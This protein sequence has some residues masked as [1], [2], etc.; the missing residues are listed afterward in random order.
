ML[1]KSYT[2]RDYLYR[3]YESL[4]SLIQKFCM[5]NGITEATFHKD[6]CKKISKSNDV[7]QDFN[8]YHIYRG[9]TS[10]ANDINRA[11]NITEKNYSILNCFTVNRM[12]TYMKEDLYYCP[13]CMKYGYHSIFHQLNFMNKCFIH[14][15]Q[16][17]IAANGQKYSLLFS[18]RE[19]YEGLEGFPNTKD[20]T[21]YKDSLLSEINEMK[22]ELP[23]SIKIID[24]NYEKYN[25][26]VLSKL[27]S[28]TKKLMCSLMFGNN[29]IKPIH[30]VSIKENDKQFENL[31]EYYNRTYRYVFDGY[32][33]RHPK[34][35]Y[36]SVY[37][38]IYDHVKKLMNNISEY[39]IHELSA[40]L[41]YNKNI[42]YN[43]EDKYISFLTSSAFLCS[44]EDEHFYKLKSV[45]EYD[46]NYKNMSF[47][48]NLS[49]L[50]TEIISHD[51]LKYHYIY[52]LVFRRIA[53]IVYNQ[54]QEQ[55]YLAYGYNPLWYEYDLKIPQYVITLAD[56]IFKIYEC[57]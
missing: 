44:L 43:E 35:Y 28:S 25:Y 8:L 49:N 10:A 30:V 5:L 17:L 22:F 46:N 23:E 2:W 34:F 24:P 20:I 50:E 38:A 13:K 54:I 21:L 47:Y 37:L 18:Q 15:E 31:I 41:R 39:K 29:T 14:K 32:V 52:T 40:N 57:I 19:P 45:W 27:H 3:P 36:P 1:D 16:S 48:V 56:D 53:D 33:R 9:T 4:W 51:S 12:K 7:L 42:L 26:P 6:L 11:L 55:F